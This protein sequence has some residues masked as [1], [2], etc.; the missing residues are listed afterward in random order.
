MRSDCVFSGIHWF[1][2]E[3]VCS[4]LF[5]SYLLSAVIYYGAHFKKTCPQSC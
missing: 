4:Y 2:E 5:R 1:K 3:V